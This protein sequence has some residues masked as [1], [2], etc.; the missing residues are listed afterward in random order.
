[1]Y[2][3]VAMYVH[4]DKLQISLAENFLVASLPCNANI[5]S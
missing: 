4:V 2:W 5:K 1:M 3:Y